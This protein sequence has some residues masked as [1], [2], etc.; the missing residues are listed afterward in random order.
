MTQDST[1]PVVVGVDGSDSADAAVALGAWEASRRHTSLRLIHAYTSAY[2]ATA[3]APYPTEYLDPIEPA[4][5]LLARA[6]T[7]ARERWTQLDVEGSVVAGSAAAALVEA[8]R[9]ASVVVVGTRGLG[10]FSGLLLGS[11][12]A[13]LAAHCRAPLI[14]TRSPEVAFPADLAWAGLPVV[15]GVDGEH[16]EVALAFAF[17][18]ASARG[19]PLLALY[20]WWV[21][22][23]SNLGPI[24]PGRFDLVA[25]EDEARRMLAE[26]VAGWRDKYP[27]VAVHLVPGHHLNPA[28]ALLEAGEHAGLVVVGRHGGNVLSRSL[29]ASTGDMVLREA[30]CPVAVVPS[31]ID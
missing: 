17:D 15:V 2:G 29:L 21:L 7:R 18:E 4:R 5:E 14:V 22:P 23:A 13:Q 20:A 27:D 6:V 11:V 12:S 31:L 28:I 16:S 24:E 10:G 26:S 8:S 19:V 1:R 3:F 25:A 30:V 9:A